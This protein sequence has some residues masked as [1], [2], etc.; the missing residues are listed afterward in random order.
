MFLGALTKNSMSSCQRIT[1][2]SEIV[3]ASL[4]AR[5]FGIRLGNR[6]ES[7]SWV[8]A[9]SFFVVCYYASGF[10]VFK[11]APKCGF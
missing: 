11:M 9:V 10:Q 2:L 7:K 8:N 4:L 1:E 3:F 5:N 6:S